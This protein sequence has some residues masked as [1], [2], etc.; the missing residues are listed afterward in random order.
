MTHLFINCNFR[1][2]K[3]ERLNSRQQI[4]DLFANGKRIST[5]NIRLV[6]RITDETDQ[7]KAQVM[8]SVP[9]KSFK[10]AV[11]RNLIKRRIREAY[12]LNK[13]SLNDHLIKINKHI[14]FAFLYTSPE[15]HEYKVI[16]ED[17]VDLL[18]KLS[19]KLLLK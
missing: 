15:I 14:V 18:N 8:I 2:S 17:V 10:K 12:R 6:Y 19:L 13:H 11:H 3:K 5:G 9:K 1:F 4:E 7:A 16:Q